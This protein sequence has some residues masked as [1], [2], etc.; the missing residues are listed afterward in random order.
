MPLH[1]NVLVRLIEPEDTTESGLVIPQSAQRD[2]NEGVV[3][4][5]GEGRR[6]DS[7]ELAPPRIV[8]GDHVMWRS[9]ATCVDVRSDEIGGDLILI[10]ERSLVGRRRRPGDPPD[11]VF[12]HR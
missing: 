1:G 12:C 7:G 2:I 8:A 9:G 11:A 4:R 6:L 10:D 5:V 3:V